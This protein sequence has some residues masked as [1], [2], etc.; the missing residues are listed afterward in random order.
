MIKRLDIIAS[1]S[2]YHHHS[3]RGHTEQVKAAAAKDRRTAFQAAVQADAEL[4]DGKW[5]RFGEAIQ[6]SHPNGDYGIEGA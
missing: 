6:C 4:F 5:A 1:P 2:K 3:T